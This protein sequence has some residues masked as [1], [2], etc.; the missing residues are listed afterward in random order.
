MWRQQ[1][2]YPRRDLVIEID[3]NADAGES[4]GRWTLGDDE[5]LFPL[6]TS[7]NTACGWHGGDPA[8]IRRSVQL[9]KEHDVSLGAHPGLPDLMGFG[10]RRMEVSHDEVVDMVTYQV[11]ALVAFAEQEG[12]TLSHVKP[13]SQLYMTIAT[14]DDLMCKVAD[15]ML[16][17]QPDLTFFMLAG[18]PAENLRSR[19][20]R[21]CAELVADMEYTDEGR[22]ILEARPPAKDPAYVADRAVAM[23]RGTLETTGGRQLEV[24]ADTLCIH[25]DR[26]NVV[27]I[28]RAIRSRFEQEDILAKAP[29]L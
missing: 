6:I 13:H 18:H 1:L 23:A 16:A 9:A 26:P 11:G 5:A 7:V 21:T 24:Q 8:I 17:L 12:V 4:Y 29:N 14:D 25:G 19:G 2:R 22:V 27:D 20:Y 10:R 28:A 15:A 3:I